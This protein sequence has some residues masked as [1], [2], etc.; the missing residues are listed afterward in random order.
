MNCLCQSGFRC[1]HT[2]FLWIGWPVK[3][4]YAI[5]GNAGKVNV[6]NDFDPS[7]ANPTK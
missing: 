3:I 6:Y 1:F 2:N 4:S 7:S 5:V